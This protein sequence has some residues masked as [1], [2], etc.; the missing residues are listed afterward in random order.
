MVLF[1]EV[2]KIYEDG[3]KAVDK[4]DLEVAK[5]EIAVL[6]GPSGCGKTTTLKMVNRL[7]S[8]T[9]GII[10]VDGQDI[11]SVNPVT[12]RRNIGYV[13]QETAL[14]PH[15]S[16]AENIAMVPKLLGWKKDRTRKRV[17]ELLEMAGLDPAIYRYR[18]P[19]QL[20]GGQKQRIGVLRALAADP[21]VVLMDEP[22]GAL[23]PIARE[24]L[25]NELLELQKTVKKTIVFVTHDMDE[26]L[27]IADKIVLMRQGHIEQIGSPDDIQHNPVNDFVRDFIGEDR[28]SQISPDSSVE[29]LVQDPILKV[30]PK[31][32]AS[33]VLDFMED[34]GCETAQ[35]VDNTGKWRGMALLW[36]L[37]RAA[38]NKG[39]VT[40]G[41]RKDRKLYIENAVLRDAAEMLA[42]Q[43]LP[44][45]VINQD[46]E[47]K[48]I[49]TQAG[50]ARLT[51]GRLTRY[52]GKGDDE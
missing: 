13:I 46:G 8:C 7:E 22:F 51:I 6:I 20:S 25:Q 28:L 17:D 5:G 29:V 47:F 50:V 36:L 4:L 18:L 34:E 3:T 33:D 52:N 30:S 9:E 26:A 45:P 14:M 21:E 15:L 43:D 32:T 39:P 48:G 23:D 27:R 41:V 12:L 19:D 10:K 38:K 49:V 44:I 42:D 35:V 16:V 11:N 24:R 2:S 1:E 31:R 40:D 37:K